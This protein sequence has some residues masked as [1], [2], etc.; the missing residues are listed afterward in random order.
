MGGVC[1]GKSIWTFTCWFR[2]IAIF[3]GISFIIWAVTKIVE[4]GGIRARKI[5]QR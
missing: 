4:G 3:T 2:Y 5:K 1:C